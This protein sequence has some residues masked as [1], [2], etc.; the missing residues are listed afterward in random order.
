MC[1]VVIEA[2]DATFGKRALKSHEN[3]GHS[4]C[5]HC[6]LKT[7]SA[8]SSSRKKE[9][10]ED[11]VKPLPQQCVRRLAILNV[12]GFPAETFIFINNRVA[13]ITS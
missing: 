10:V 3:H 2:E 11:R 8:S 1:A 9:K 7:H 4:C 6:A 12:F 5:V 13:R